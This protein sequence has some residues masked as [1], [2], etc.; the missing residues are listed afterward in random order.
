MFNGGTRCVPGKVERTWPLFVVLALSWPPKSTLKTGCSGLCN[1][2]TYR[3]ILDA[4]KFVCMVSCK[5]LTRH[6]VHESVGHHGFNKHSCE[7]QQIIINTS[8]FIMRH[9]LSLHEREARLRLRGSFSMAVSVPS[10]L[11]TAF[12]SRFLL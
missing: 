6:C 12:I 3:F 5:F 4:A 11:L 7:C 2:I 1:R 8:V 9:V 10:S